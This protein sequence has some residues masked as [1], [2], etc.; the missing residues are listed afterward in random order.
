MNAARWRIASACALG[1]S[2][3]A[4]G[5]PCQDNASQ[6][7]IEAEDGTVLV[8][9]VCDGA[10]TAAFA[11]QGS[12]LAA[13]GFVRAVERYIKEGGRVVGITREIASTWIA[14]ASNSIHQE[15]MRDGHNV[16]EYACTLLAAIIGE[17][18]AAFLQVGDGAIVVS[19]GANDG[20][21]W[22]FWPQHGE[23]ANT[24]NF[25]TTPGVDTLME[26]GASKRSIEELAIF[27]DGIE[28]LVLNNAT[29]QVHAAF[30]D[31]MFPPVRQS[32]AG[33]NSKLSSDLQAY[34]LSP[35]IADR[36]DDDKTLILATCRAP[37]LSSDS[38]YEQAN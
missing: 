30:F 16:R 23:F 24:T 1:T 27:S 33:L 10:G 7:L 38:A 3:A 32:S 26:F 21:A 17:R 8:A 13:E 31:A 19:E 18:E 22:V 15:A 37:P 5:T 9:V 36:T 25:I 20:W 35:R 12:K 4:N 2:H 11:E 14:E 6:I 29:K 28:H 34:L